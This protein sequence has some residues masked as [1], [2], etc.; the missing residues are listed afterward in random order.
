[1]KIRIVYILL[2]VDEVCVN[3]M[4]LN[5]KYEDLLFIKEA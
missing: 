4:I 1:M 5:A 3:I 2:Y